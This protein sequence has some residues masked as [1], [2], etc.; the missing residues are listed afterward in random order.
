[1]MMMM[2]SQAQRP[3]FAFRQLYLG[4]A[5]GPVGMF[6]MIADNY[7]ALGKRSHAVST[8]LLAALLFM[9][10]VTDFSVIKVP[11]M[12]F[13]IPIAAG[14]MLWVGYTYKTD[15]NKEIEEAEFNGGPW[16]STNA[17]LSRILL[18]YLAQFIALVLMAA[19]V[20]FLIRA[21]F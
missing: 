2:S 16:H 9:I 1:M 6:W 11:H 17:C 4:L 3:L 8:Y 10:V 13:S 12:H 7:R 18:A 15:Q 19:T 21:G 5:A 14:I 20:L